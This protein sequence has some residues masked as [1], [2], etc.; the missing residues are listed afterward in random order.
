MDLL[1]D[2]LWP[3]ILQSFRDLCLPA[4]QANRSRRIH[5]LTAA[6]FATFSL[7]VLTHPCACCWRSAMVEIV[8]LISWT[9]THELYSA[10][11]RVYISDCRLTRASR[12]QG[13]GAALMAEVEN[14]GPCSR[15]FQ[16]WLGGLASKLRCQRRFTRR[17][18]SLHRRR[19][20]PL[21]LLCLRM[22]SN[23]K[24]IFSTARGV[25]EPSS[26]KDTDR[27]Y[28]IWLAS[29]ASSTTE[30]CEP[31]RPRRR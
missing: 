30:F 20:N 6:Q 16:A 10:D 15:C 2:L 19:G 22:K 18:G 14:L 7:S 28:E 5:P 1:L 29:V 4:C 11:T 27:L 24:G 8:G 12:G 26:T 9:L 31:V 25:F 21:S 3:R 23:D 17:I 13:V